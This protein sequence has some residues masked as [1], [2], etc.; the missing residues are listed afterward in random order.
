MP[1]AGG[2]PAYRK[3]C[4]DVVARGYEGFAFSR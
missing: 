1:Y 3:I 4:E 2:M